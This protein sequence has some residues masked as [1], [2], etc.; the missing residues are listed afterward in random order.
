[1]EGIGS[2]LE[3]LTSDG[4]SWVSVFEAVPPEEAGRMHVLPVPGAFEA[5]SQIEKNVKQ[6]SES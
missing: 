2:G 4:L 6:R 1:M 5:L 3:N